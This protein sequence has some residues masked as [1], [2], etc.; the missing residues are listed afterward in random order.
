MGLRHWVPD[1]TMTM[2]N[3]L[4]SLRTLF[5]IYT[6]TWLLI[7]S[8]YILMLVFYIKPWSVLEPQPDL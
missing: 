3:N 5:H 1:M 6:F 8:T 7:S 4:C 2:L